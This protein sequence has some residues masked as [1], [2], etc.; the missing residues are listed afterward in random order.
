MRLVP[1]TDGL[2]H[3]VQDGDDVTLCWR[4]AGR[5]RWWRRRAGWAT[6]GLCRDRAASI[7]GENLGPRFVYNGRAR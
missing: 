6:C 5:T 1:S 4:L 7:T 3:V 2:T